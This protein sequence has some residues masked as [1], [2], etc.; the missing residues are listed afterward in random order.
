[1]KK[2]N[3]KGILT[4]DFIFSFA[5]VMGLFQ[6][7]YVLTFT[8]MIAH[9]TQYMTF[10]A[11]RVYSAGHLD[12]E[13]Q[14]SQAEAKFNQLMTESPIASFFRGQFV[15][16]NFEANEFNDLTPRERWRQLYAGTRVLF[17]SNI[18][19]FNVP[20]LGRTNTELEGDAFRATMSSFLYREPSAAECFQFIQDRG[21][22]ILR[23][24]SKYE[25]ARSSGFNPAQ[26]G[27]FA[28][29]GC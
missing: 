21:Q 25:R 4:I 11:A 26:I 1:M 8:L 23:L 22:A 2:K 3:Q 10:A 19:D 13:T 28:D 5:M 17:Q 7:F 24:E 6:I 16:S 15:L 18:L 29:N 27:L 14:K 12:E 9:V 20:F